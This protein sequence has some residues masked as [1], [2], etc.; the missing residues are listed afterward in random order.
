M[1][2]DYAQK[3]KVFTIWT[4]TEAVCR[5]L[6]MDTRHLGKFQ[7]ISIKWQQSSNHHEIKMSIKNNLKFKNSMLLQILKDLKLCRLK[8]KIMGLLECYIVNYNETMILELDRWSRI[9][10]DSDL[11]I[12]NAMH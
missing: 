1:K 7:D 3:L 5:P 12:S 9:D 6:Y 10:E 8:K 2:R 4:F 11:E